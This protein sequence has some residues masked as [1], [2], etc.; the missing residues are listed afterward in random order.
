MHI[1]MHMFWLQENVP[2]GPFQDT[3]A[4]NSAYSVEHTSEQ[5]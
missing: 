4:G 1:F 5:P 3:F 2:L